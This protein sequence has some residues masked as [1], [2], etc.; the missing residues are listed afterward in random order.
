MCNP[1]PEYLAKIHEIPISVKLDFRHCDYTHAWLGFEMGSHGF[2]MDLWD[3]QGRAWN[4]SVARP[5]FTWRK[6]RWWYINFDFCKRIY[7]F[8][9]S[10]DIFKRGER[11]KKPYEKEGFKGADFGTT[12][13]ATIPEG[14]GEEPKEE[15]KNG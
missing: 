7:S 9:I 1:S 4:A 15:A 6:H 10:L 8:S 14:L 5:G 12:D 2:S 3:E 13:F 11:P